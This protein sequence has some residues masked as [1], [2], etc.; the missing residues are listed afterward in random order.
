MSI[1]HI[2][3][4]QFANLITTLTE[5]LER[6]RSCSIAHLVQFPFIAVQVGTMPIL[7]SNYTTAGSTTQSQTFC[8]HILQATYL[9]VAVSLS[10]QR[11]HSHYDEDAIHRQATYRRVDAEW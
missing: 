1:A 10:R 6:S 2:V 9:R 8:K 5:V 4:V 7:R 3:G 11:I